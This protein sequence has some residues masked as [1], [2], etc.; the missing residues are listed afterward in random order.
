MCQESPLF[1]CYESP[2]QRRMLV[3]LVLV[4]SPLCALEKGQLYLVMEREREG[5]GAMSP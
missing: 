1:M 3:V 5:E 4:E 2:E